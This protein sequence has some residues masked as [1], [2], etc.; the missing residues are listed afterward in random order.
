M[1]YQHYLGRHDSTWCSDKVYVHDDSIVVSIEK[2]K[3]IWT[4]YRVVSPWTTRTEI[5]PINKYRFRDDRSA[6]IYYL[7]FDDKGEVKGI[8]YS[9]GPGSIFKQKSSLVIQLHRSNSYSHASIFRLPY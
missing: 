1:D 6:G 4:G 2:G 5:T 3:L 7:E 9:E 8:R